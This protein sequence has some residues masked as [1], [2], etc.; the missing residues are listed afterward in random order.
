MPARYLTIRRAPCAAL[1]IPATG[2]KPF[3]APVRQIR[4]LPRHLPAALCALV[5][6]CV[7]PAQASAQST[8][9]P[10][11]VAVACTCDRAALQKAIPFVTVV[12]PPASAD[13]TVSVTGQ[14]DQW[15][16]IAAGFGRFAGRDRTVSFNMPAG[17]AADAAMADLARVMKL[18]L[19]EYVAETSL[20]PRLDVSFRRPAATSQTQ[21]LQQDQKDPWNYWVFRLNASTYMSGE[22]SATDVSYDFNASANRT[23]ERWK[24]RLA[25][26]RSLS[27]SSFDLDDTT[28]ITSRLS[29][30]SINGL[31]VKSLGPR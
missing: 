17:A 16:M 22:Q 2:T 15:S 11:T 25:G 14:A 4:A 29:D 6:V 23:T 7:T 30:W 28:T 3:G 19:A 31:S 13:V 10:L 1:N 8:E 12:A 27:R 24:F 9:T 26:Y 5:L 20:G 21:P 18:I